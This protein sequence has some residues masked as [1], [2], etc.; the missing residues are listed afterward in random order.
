M[1]IVA[2]GYG[3]DGMDLCGIPLGKIKTIKFNV[4]AEK[5]RFWVYIIVAVGAITF[6]LGD[7]YGHQGLMGVGILVF[8]LGIVFR[9]S[10]NITRRIPDDGGTAPNNCVMNGDDRFRW[11]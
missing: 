9:M 7:G 11:N 3:I 10:Y 8:L 4:S 1:R 5:P 2:S 6:A